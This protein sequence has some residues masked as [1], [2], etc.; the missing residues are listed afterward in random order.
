MALRLRDVSL[1]FGVDE[2]CLIDKVARQLQLERASLSNFRIVRRSLDARKK[3]Q[4]RWVY[5]VEFS[6]ANETQLLQLHD[7]KGLLHQAV[8]PQKISLPKLTGSYH[9]LIVGMGPAGLFA[10]KLLAESGA[11]VTL[12]ERGRP[13]PVPA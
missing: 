7:S 6:T 12:V 10:A 8:A 13:S 9:V 11:Q 1:P 3:P 2:G 4:L 5:T